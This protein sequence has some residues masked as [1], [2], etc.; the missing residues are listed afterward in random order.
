MLTQENVAAILQRDRFLKRVVEAPGVFV[1]SGEDGLARVPSR[2]Q[3]GREVT[4][5][6]S[7]EAEAQR[8]ADLVARRPRV[9]ELTVS[10][11]LAEVLPALASLKRFAGVDWSPAG[12]E[13]EFDANDLAERVRL[14]ILEVF[15]H[16]TRGDGKVWILE[17]ANGPA[18]LVSSVRST[19]YILP[20]WAD[21]REAER[22][23]VGP[24]A[25][26]MPV[27]IPLDTFLER[28]L[29]WLLEN[30]H[31][32][33]PGHLAGAG[34]LELEPHGLKARYAASAPVAV[35]G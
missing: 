35:P 20:C 24:W 12:L 17:D 32:V 29:L 16:R 13:P 27:D 23:I 10:S 33:S 26:M 34:S 7:E 2:R 9:K 15:L 30:K 18:L 28:K 5:L 4:L 14:E 22:R 25:D 19:Q 3:R 21:R 31:L 8:W 1:V 11:L 6:W